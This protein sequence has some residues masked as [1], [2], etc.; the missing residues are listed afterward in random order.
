MASNFAQS[1]IG[2]LDFMIYPYFNSLADIIP[3]MEVLTKQIKDNVA[4]YKGLVD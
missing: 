3:K 2:F 4:E 1:Q